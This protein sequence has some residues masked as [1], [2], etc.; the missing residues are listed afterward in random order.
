MNARAGVVCATVSIAAILLYASVFE[1]RRVRLTR[2]EVRA[3]ALARVLSGRTVA[4]LGDLHFGPVGE[5]V[6]DDALRT[7]RDLRPD[8]I[9]LTGDYVAWGSRS[10]AYEHAFDFLAR[11]KA[12][13]GVYAVLGDADRTFSRKSCEFC[14]PAG[15]GDPVTRHEVVFFGDE[16]RV[17]GLPQGSLRIAGVDPDLS[18]PAG[19]R[20]RA[21]LAG[22]MPTILLSHS[23]VV[24]REI[25]P[26]KEVL[27]LAG[28]THGGQIRMP[29]WFW[30]QIR[31]KPDP[32]HVHGYFKDGR[33]SLFVTR[34]VGTSHVRFRL[35]APPEIAVLE[36]A[37]ATQ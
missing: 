7:L 27:T 30:R 18:R 31:F 17:I 9:L 29:G 2:I 20:L 14:H 10:E 34:G 16:S 21:L 15:S 5:P 11:L 35:G 37:G 25:D 28:D 1:P 8:L 23:S 12:P 32:E 13:L 6:A 26:S 33:K 4:L 22:D 24:Y 19:E 36:F 3:G